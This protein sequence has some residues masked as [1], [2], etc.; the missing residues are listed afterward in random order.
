MYRLHTI[1]VIKQFQYPIKLT[2]VVLTLRYRTDCIKVI[3]LL[4]TSVTK[5][6][7]ITT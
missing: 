4:H 3:T 7:N 2:S 5:V 1:L 6:I